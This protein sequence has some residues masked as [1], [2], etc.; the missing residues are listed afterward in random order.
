MFTVHG[1]EV[2]LSATSLL[3]RPHPPTRSSP[4]LQVGFASLALYKST[5]HTWKS[6]RGQPSYSPLPT[7]PEL[8]LINDAWHRRR[9]GFSVGGREIENHVS[10]FP[11]PFLFSVN[12]LCNLRGNSCELYMSYDVLFLWI[13]FLGRA[14]VRASMT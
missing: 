3:Q 12:P 6:P 4:P 2:S 10:F 1:K 7:L 9:E 8:S 11:F 14:Y 5:M 13:T